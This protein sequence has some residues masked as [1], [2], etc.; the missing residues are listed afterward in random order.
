MKRIEN[1]QE[2]MNHAFRS[3]LWRKQN[4]EWRIAFHQAT[5]LA[6]ST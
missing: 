4:G 1:G 2:R 3:S 6:A 5:P